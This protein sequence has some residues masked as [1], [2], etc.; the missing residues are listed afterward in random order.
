[1]LVLY[2]RTLMVDMESLMESLLGTLSERVVECE[3]SSEPR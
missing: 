3:G 1:M 2:D